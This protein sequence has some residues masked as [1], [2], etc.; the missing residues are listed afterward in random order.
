LSVGTHVITA[1]EADPAGN[2]SAASAAMAPSLFIA[3][4]PAVTTQAATDIASSTATGNGT[5]VALG[6]PSPTAHGLVWN[7]TGSPTLAD[8]STN[9]GAASAAGPFTGALTGLS[10][11]TPYY[12]RAYATNDLT[13]VYGDQ[14]TFTSLQFYTL[15]YA[16]GAG[17]SITGNLLQTVDHGASGT[18]VTAIADT[19]YHFVDWSDGVTTET[20]TDTNVTANIN[21]TANFAIDT[22][23]ISGTVTAGGTGLAGVTM[24]GLPGSPVTG[25]DG[26]Y[27]ANVEYGFSGTVTPT[28]VYYAFDPVSNTYTN[29]TANITGQNYA[30][31]LITTP[32]RQALIAF[33]DSTHGTSW[34]HN[35]GWKTAPLYPDGFALPGTEGTWYGLTVDSGTQ[36]V[37]Q[38]YMPLNNLSGPL[39]AALENL[40][41]LRGLY[42][43]DNLLSG[44]IPP[45]LGNLAALQ[46]LRLDHNQLN[47]S[48]PVQLANIANLQT[49]ELQ[50]NQLNGLIPAVLGVLDDLIYLN[51]SE[52]LLTGTIP[53]ELGNL[54]R[55]QNLQL[56]SNQLSGEIPSDLGYL[57]G[58]INLFLNSNQ[59]SGAIP[60]SFGNLRNLQMLRLNGNMLKGQIPSSL[61]NL[62]ALGSSYTNIG[63]NALYTSDETL[64]T[65]LNSKDA[66]WAA[67]QTIAP[68]GVTATSLDNAVIRISWLPI[69][70][71]SDTGY[72]KVMMAQTVGGPYTLAGQ[73]ENKTT[74]SL[75]VTGLAPGQRY[76]FV[77][78]THTNAHANNP[79][80]VESENSNEATAVAWTQFN[81][82]ISGTVTLGGSPLAGVVMNG[83][84]GSPVTNA[85]GVYTGTEAAGST[86]LVTPTLDGYTFTPTSRTYTG[87]TTD[88]TGQNYDAVAIL[89]TL[90]VTS[91][92]G[93]ES[94]ATGLMH[95]VTWTQTGVTGSV[96]IDLYKGGVFQKILGGAEAT[97]GTFSWVI[98]TNETV[99]TDYRVLVW[100]SGVSDNSDADFTI[101]RTV[102]VD[103]NKDGQEDILWRY[104]GGGGY[105]GLNVAWLMNQSGTLSPIR[106]EANQAGAMGTSLLTGSS[107]NMTYQAPLE[108]GTPGTP[109]PRRSFKTILDGGEASAL[110]PKQVMRDPMDHSRELSA[111]KRGRAKDTEI[112][113]IPTRRDALNVN[114]LGFGTGETAALQLNTEVLLSGITDTAWEIVGTGDF[115]K[116][117]NT[118]IL[119]RYYGTGPYQGLNDVWYMNGTGFL[120]E[121]LITTVTDTDW[122]IVGT[123]DF[124]KDGNT[125]I[126][127]R[128]CGTGPLQ[129]VDVVWYMNGAELLGEA[130]VNSVTDTNWR[131]AGTGDFNGDGST[132]ILW[133]NYGTG[134][135]QG[136][137]IIWYMNGARQSSEALLTTV[138]DTAWEIVGTGDF[139]G[140][141]QTDI[142]WR[143]YG[144]GPYQGLNVIWYMNGAGLSSEE[145]INT[146]TD[147]N[148]RIVNR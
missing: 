105:Q 118:D 42:L 51:L 12:V 142:V 47:G 23:T 108:V 127:W 85:S 7:T 88:Q 65:F 4:A 93:G 70:Y 136:M 139:N 41:N 49:L 98:A 33:Y 6:L 81:V 124:N 74:S 30:A 95:S 35:A 147:I 137:N 21:A 122:R 57:A 144:T 38:I 2:I 96:R 39:P 68:A 115:N 48:I 112:M 58:L 148:W 27:T 106:L 9:A 103:F 13:T 53:P 34:A 10:P 63:Y 107:S 104:Y 91:P 44:P 73:T 56:H 60:E 64:I 128:N 77:V 145:L 109:V 15:T 54:A 16:A 80:A 24:A 111:S 28:N 75:N 99:G 82:T 97:A 140:D 25:L 29:V 61:V 135:F 20:R 89:P 138:T 86:L 17:G 26:S 78:Q 1:T 113:N 110:R 83:L 116:D 52:N 117:G 123:G 18:T 129:G 11:N 125:D 5:I 143:N 114:A 50:H 133:R 146:V 55:M 14:V 67:T 8:S 141:Q 32:Q 101:V 66:D 120:N 121:E 102:K 72:Y 46:Y 79:G 126:L 69:A 87:V 62:T 84:T 45:E 76:Y 132:D 43:S 100:Q 130:L 90:T 31:V 131:I 19:G 92:N 71:T 94:W 59:L 40:V 36:Q 22:Y 3:V 134:A 37:T 119:W